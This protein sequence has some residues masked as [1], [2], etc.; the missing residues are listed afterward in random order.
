MAMFGQATLVVDFA[1]LQRFDDE[2]ARALEGNY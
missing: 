2:L 1:H